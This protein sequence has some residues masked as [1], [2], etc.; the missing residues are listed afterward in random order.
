MYKIQTQKE[1]SILY[2]LT[3]HCDGR[4]KKKKKKQSCVQCHIRYRLL[5]RLMY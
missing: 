2:F 5:K 1:T 4:K 3:E